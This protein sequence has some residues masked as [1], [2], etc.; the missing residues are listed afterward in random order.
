MTILY[1]IPVQAQQMPDAW[2]DG[3]TE[4]RLKGIYR[5]GEFRAEVFT[6][7]WWA[8]S[9]GFSVREN[10]PGSK[11]SSDWLFQLGTAFENHPGNRR[12]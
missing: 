7:K 5:Q 3:T 11:K 10:D 12:R 9:S 2:S 1:T 6:G 4:A 8:E